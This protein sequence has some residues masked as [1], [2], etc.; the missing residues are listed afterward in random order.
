MNLL[1]TACYAVHLVATV[2]WLGGL[3]MFSLFLY[4]MLRQHPNR[5]LVLSL[6]KRFRPMANL[7]LVV[8]LGTGMVQM[9]ADENYSGFLTIAENTWSLAM[10][11]KHMAFGGMILLMLFIQFV[12]VPEL[13]RANLL[14]TKGDTTALEAVMA[15]EATLTRVLMMLGGIILIFTALATA[16]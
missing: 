6:Q 7:S 2:V 11:L 8:L 9:S 15:R 10:F 12:I 1:L 13:E 16:V 5:A 4:P 3:M 14:A